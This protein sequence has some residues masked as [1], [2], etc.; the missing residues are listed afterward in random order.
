LT[1]EAEPHPGSGAPEEAEEG[2]T[3]WRLGPRERLMRWLGAGAAIVLALIL[4]LGLAVRYGLLT[5]TGRN[6]IVAPLEGLQIGPLGKLHVEGLT[7]DVLRDFRV[8]RLAIVDAQGVWLD[9]HDV[10]IRWRSVELLQ[11]RVH[12]ESLSAASVEI[13]RRPLL[14][15]GGQGGP[16]KLPVA[17]KLD[18][19]QLR[20]ATDPAFSVQRGLFDIGAR[21]TLARSGAFG[22]AVRAQSRLRQ[23]DGLDARFDIGLHK[24]IR[25]DLEA[26]EGKGGAL[27][28]AAGLPAKQPFNL[29]AHAEGA[30]SDGHVKVRAQSGATSIAQADGVWTPGGGGIVAW[31]SL[32][33]SSLTDRYAHELG[34][35][36][37]LAARG[38]PSGPGLEQINAR[39]SADNA[40]IQIAGLIDPK[41]S[42]APRGLRVQAQVN[43]PNRLVAA[44]LMGPF[45]ADGLLTQ[46]SKGWGWKGRASVDRVSA[47]D[48][49]LARVAGPVEISQSSG[50]LD[51]KADLQGSA[52]R[53]AGLL[54]SAAGASPHVAL[55]A[56]RL[57][58]GR[59]L[60]RSLKAKGDGLNLEAQGQRTLFGALNFSGDLKIDKLAAARAGAHGGLDARWSAA[61]A[62]AD[63]PWRFTVD[64]SGDKLA[65]GYAELD[66]LLGPKPRLSASATYDH[67]AIAVTKADLTGSAAQ[68][69]AV[70]VVAKDGALK[71]ALKWTADGP[72]TIGP[73]EVAG[74]ARGG[75]DLA[76]VWSAP[77]A[78][79]TADFEQIALPGMALK[80]AH[81]TLAFAKG[82]ADT[83]GQIAITAGSDYGPAHAKADFKLL[84]DGVAL[85]NIDADAGGLTA[86]GAASL[87]G[88]D[89]SSA[90]LTLAATTGAFL[91][92]GRADARLKIVSGA[93]GGQG[94]LILTAVGAA[95]RGADISFNSLQIKASGPLAR[96][97]YTA[98]AD[99]VGEGL[100]FHL[101][102]AGVAD[103]DGPQRSLTFDGSGKVRQAPFR[104]LS[105]ATLVTDGA[106]AHLALS[107]SYGSGRADVD[108]R[109]TG[110]EVRGKATLDG[111][112]L[113]ALGEDVAGRV[114][115]E[116][117]LE[118]QGSHLDG[119]LDARVAGVRTRD[120][121]TKLALDGTITARLAGSRITLDASAG[122]SGSS[123][124]ASVSLSL[125]TVAT[126]APL[127][128]AVV[129][130]EPIQG[131]F[132]ANGE[133]QPIWDLFFGGDRTLGGRLVAQGSVSGS[134]NSPRYVGH[135]T[136]TGGRFEDAAT[137]LKLRNLVAD[138]DLADTVLTVSKFSASDAK[139]GVVSGS[140]QVDLAT[141][142]ASSLTLNAKGFQL[143]DNDAA[144]A[145]ASGAVTVTRG[146]DGKAELKG[147]L[148]IDRADIS[149][150]S[151]RA[152]PGVISMDVTEINLP[153]GAQAAQTTSLAQAPAVGLDI[154]LS[155]PGRIFV[156]GFG[157]N[158]EMSLAAHVGG[159][160]AAPVL[161][162]TAHVVRG[163]YDLAGKRFEIDDQ[164][165]VYLASDLDKIRL[166]LNARLD[167]PTI[168]AIIQIQG[169]A[170]KPKVIL[171]S[172]PVLPSDE[173]LSEVLFGRSA[174]QLS[175]VEAAQL[176]AAV[177]SLATGGGFDVMGGLRNFAK[178]DRLALGGGDTPSALNPIGSRYVETGVTVSGGKYIGNRV[179]LE[180][181][182]GGRLG[183]SA[184]VEVK[185]T[186]AFSVISQL[187]GEQGAKLAVRWRLDYGKAKPAKVK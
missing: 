25:L 42:T 117:T 134:L 20:L 98:A 54:A 40:V 37:K 103:A 114:S 28:G 76:G 187:G 111:V 51:L 26:G 78:D 151:A 69:G 135:A 14:Q 178:L 116:L 50:E 32:T 43:A 95:P 130:T 107:L 58:D 80:P 44:P 147:A 105:P 141:N 34:P 87:R 97:A 169:T 35:Q 149:A 182:G 133:L 12:I 99:G 62:K 11:R 108:V 186:R 33:A 70:G 175:P 138:V 100:P 170:A 91:S 65:S 159:T 17:L 88:S 3:P 168:T 86:K 164:G 156:K 63:Q 73:L 185:A 49:S 52:G 106:N 89:A 22:G 82:P 48:D 41:K 146:S 183:P 19:L 85:E 143:L 68:I 24:R 67:G 155:A 174:A 71:F 81:V 160:T 61:Q 180:L 4:A 110:G 23:G 129:R 152:P 131:R 126:A 45:A 31:A 136:L 18:R 128:I 144:K 173:V 122:Q 140:G 7:G 139:A 123:D 39:L 84:A 137:G 145:V 102:G 30:V 59:L 104:T 72:F 176:A 6:L 21:L 79:L 154:Q 66:R 181:T 36:L 64:A 10:A 148:T 112:D 83:S 125:P 162:G 132:D 90:D 47:F 15:G 29:T 166:D 150:V 153:G 121:P 127:R 142:G 179:Y 5:E 172:I 96:M 124:K 16:A 92:A 118:G 77:R 9:A 56:A 74:K 157:L 1:D 163:D 46:T 13:L 38:A 165:V 167:D 93:G 119:D 101:T 171:T 184:Q 120:A 55:E 94:D 8:R 60:I 161:T 109:Q 57:A 158:A 177:T 53:G 113:S 75:G 27:A 115:G 2:H